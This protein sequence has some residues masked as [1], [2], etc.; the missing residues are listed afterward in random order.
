L[1]QQLAGLF[2]DPPTAPSSTNALKIAL[3]S[4]GSRPTM[5]SSLRNRSRPKRRRNRR[6]RNLCS[7]SRHRNHDIHHRHI[8]HHDSRRSRVLPV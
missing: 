6:N 3:N 1:A 4:N 8:H 5:R 7:H 2:V